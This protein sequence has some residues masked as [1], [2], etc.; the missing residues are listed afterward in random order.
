MRDQPLDQP[1]NQPQG[2]GPEEAAETAEAA[3][4]FGARTLLVFAAAFVAAALFA[5][6]A[7]LVASSSPTVFRLDRHTADRLH[8]YGLRHRPFIDAMKALS[9]FGSP[10]AWWIIL[11]AVA[12]WLAYQRRWRLVAFVAVTALGSSLLNALIK[13]AVGRVRPKLPDP[14]ATA[15]GKSFPSGHAQSAIVGYGILLVIFLPV[16]PRRLRLWAIG[17]S[18]VLVLAIGFSRIALGV[19]YLS[20]VVG[21][22]LVGAVW[23]AGLIAAFRAW[24]RD[25]AQRPSPTEAGREPGDAGRP[26]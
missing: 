19:H 11:G 25:L 24:R 9:D 18:V 10:V 20:D 3:A 13:R 12:V 22:Y 14:L 15:G 1:S 16:L 26:V 6:L 21:A 8:G 2:D 4:R 7:A 17:V 23:L 5:T